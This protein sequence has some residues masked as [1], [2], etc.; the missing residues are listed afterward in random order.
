V[1]LLIT[2]GAD[3]N[4]KEEDG[5]TP[6]HCAVWRNGNQKGEGEPLIALL[7]AKGADV[8]A[9]NNKGQTPLAMAL[10]MGLPEEAAALRAHG[11]R[12]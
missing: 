1:E 3:V 10:E 9:R 6:L 7:V 5:D 12:E 2:K 11:A 8:T 4:P